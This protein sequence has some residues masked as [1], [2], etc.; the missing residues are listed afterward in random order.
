[1]SETQVELEHVPWLQ[2][3]EQHSVEALQAS[4]ACVHCATDEVQ[5]ML[6]ASQRPEQQSEP[7]RH[8][9]P[10]GAQLVDAAPPL[11]PLPPLPLDPFTAPSGEIDVPP[12]G[13]PELVPLS[14]D[15]LASAA[16]PLMSCF[17]E[18]Q[19][20]LVTAHTSSTTETNP[21]IQ[22]SIEARCVY[23]H[24]SD[25]RGERPKG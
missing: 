1:V 21:R 17:F 20:A 11:L 12:S 2:L 24:V 15:T 10:K 25:R 4:A 9:S 5:V 6:P 18:L 23:Q 13:E 22:A 16:G 3:S 14:G 19:P 8:I 7:A